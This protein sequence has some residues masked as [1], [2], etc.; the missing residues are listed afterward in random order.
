MPLPAGFKVNG[1]QTKSAELSLPPRVKK[2]IALLE[3]MPAN[4]LL[5]SVEVSIKT[6]LSFGGAW[7]S[8]P[9]LL[10]YREKVDGKLLWGNKKTI[11]RL[12]QQLAEPEETPNEN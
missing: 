5:L 9:A 6:G 2:I 1:V 7:T 11:V 3:S 4:E 8:H 12:R 10:D